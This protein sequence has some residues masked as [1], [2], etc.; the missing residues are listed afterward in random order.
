[1]E[2]YRRMDG[3]IQEEEGMERYSK[4]EME[5]YRRRGWRDTGG[6]DGEIQEEGWRD[7]GEGR[8]GVER[9]GG[10]GAK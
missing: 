4:R 8:G 6:G 3:E 1:M 5:R 2:R 10:Q 7:R 9:R